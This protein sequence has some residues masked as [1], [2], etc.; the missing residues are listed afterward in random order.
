MAFFSVDR[1]RKD[2]GGIW[3]ISPRGETIRASSSQ[4]MDWLS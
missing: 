2:C 1:V 3:S 4:L